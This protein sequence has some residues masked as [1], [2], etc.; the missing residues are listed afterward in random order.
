MVL[1]WLFRFVVS[2]FSTCHRSENWRGEFRVVSK[3][4]VMASKAVGLKRSPLFVSVFPL[5]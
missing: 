2:G 3:F 5:L 4:C 1:F